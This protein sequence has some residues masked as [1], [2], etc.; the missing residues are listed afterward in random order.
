MTEIMGNPGA[1]EIPGFL[2]SQPFS[3]S[4]KPVLD[5]KKTNSVRDVLYGAYCGGAKP[6][7]R[8]SQEV[9]TPGIKGAR[10]GS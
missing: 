3:T 2:M 7:I 8:C 1:W 4:F 6:G 10:T 5:G 9:V